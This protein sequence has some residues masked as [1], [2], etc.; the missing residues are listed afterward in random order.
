MLHK[1]LDWDLMAVVVVVNGTLLQLAMVNYFSVC[2]M[3]RYYCVEEL[4]DGEGRK[5]RS[6]IIMPGI[7][8]GVSGRPEKARADS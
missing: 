2:L 4:A 8:G 7:G 1:K 5:T 6:W 3:I